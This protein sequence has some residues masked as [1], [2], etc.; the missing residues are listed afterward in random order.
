[1]EWGHM[2]ILLF[3]VP[4]MNHRQPLL[5]VASSR[6]IH[7]PIT[8]PRGSVYRNVASWCGVTEQNDKKCV[9]RLFQIHSL[10]LVFWTVCA[11]TFSTNPWLLE[12]REKE[13]KNVISSQTPHTADTKGHFADRLQ[14]FTLKMNMLCSITGLTSPSFL[15][16]PWENK[17][18]VSVGYC[19]T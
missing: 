18:C 13:K 11:L 2:V 14:C 9:I 12:E 1:M 6:A 10:L 5:T 15:A 16:M 17:P 19:M 7:T 3:C 8:L 4:G